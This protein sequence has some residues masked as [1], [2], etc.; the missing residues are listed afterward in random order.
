MGGLKVLFVAAE[1]VPFSKTGGL[2]DVIGA[3]PQELKEIGVDVRVMLP[4]Y[5][6]TPAQYEN[7]MELVH[8]LLVHVGWRNQYCG[9]F[10]LEHEGVVFYFVENE[11]HFDRPGTYGFFDD[12]ERFSFFNRAILEALPGLDFRPDLI[13][14]HD[15]HAGMIPVMLTQYRNQ[16][17]FSKIKTVFTIH[18]LQYQGVFSKSILG[19]LLGLGW[20]HFNVNGVEFYDQVSFMKGGLN[21]ANALTTVSP[22]Y[23][24][25][26]QTDFYG[27]QLDGVLARRQSF[28]SGIINGIDTETW[29]PETDPYISENYTWK[30]YKKKEENKK[31]LQEELGLKQDK[32]IPLVGMVTRLASQKGL[33]LVAQVIDDILELNLQLVVLGTGEKEF[34]AIFSEYAKQYPDQ[35]SATIEFKEAL[36]HK[37]YAASDLFLMPSLFE[38]CGLGQLIAM[39]YG[40]LPLVR[41][42]GG[43]KDTVK[44]YNEKTGVSNGFSFVDYSAK[45]LLTTIQRA[46]KLY[47]KEKDSWK[48]MVERAMQEDFSWKKSAL[49]YKALYKSLLA[50]TDS[51][52]I[53]KKS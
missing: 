23:A 47:E 51:K 6:D 33:D 44:P 36:A 46:L 41:E 3:L 11:A 38:P 4:K 49:K 52:K 26:I 27:A 16:E 39:R 32:S 14:C 35:V 7:K 17:F 28:L 48:Q 8:C 15:W 24:Q 1:G 22:T 45:E 10:R 40:S 18:N 53:L 2:A 34:E 9:I 13:H 21:Y 31:A 43:L 20:E 19:D 12:G 37:I 29:N 42:T 5:G 50:K 25:E 30:T